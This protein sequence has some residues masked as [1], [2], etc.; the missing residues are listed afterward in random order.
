MLHRRLL[1]HAPRERLAA[2]RLE[3]CR[4]DLQ[5]ELTPQQ[6]A[7]RLH[8]GLAREDPAAHEP[9]V[10]LRVHEALADEDALP[11][12]RLQQQIGARLDQAVERLA[13]FLIVE[14]LAVRAEGAGHMVRHARLELARAQAA[15]GPL[16]AG[17]LWIGRVVGRAWCG[18]A[19]RTMER[20]K[21]GGEAIMWGETAHNCRRAEI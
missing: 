16:A 15:A 1:P 2:D 20:E 6:P 5:R 11:V 21:Q 3:A 4:I 19:G 10:G 12:G 9:P 8:R 13:V 18:G 17:A 7:A 14:E